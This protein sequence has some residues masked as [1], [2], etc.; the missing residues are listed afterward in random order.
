M[1][2]KMVETTGSGRKNM[3]E[4]E[5]REAPLGQKEDEGW[6]EVTTK[7]K[8]QLNGEKSITDVASMPGES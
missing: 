2:K 1:M 5:G 6:Q 7:K 4:K 8:R 3:R